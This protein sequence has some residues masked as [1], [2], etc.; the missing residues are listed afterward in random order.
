MSTTKRVAIVGAVLSAVALVLPVEALTRPSTPA[1]RVLAISY[2]AHDGLSRRAYLILPAWYGPKKHPPIPLVISP[3]GRGVGARANIRRWGD[4]PARGGFAVINPEGQGRRLTLFSWGDPGEIRDLARMPSI[5]ERAATWL[6]I[7]RRRVYAFGGSMGGQETLLLLARYPRL[8]AGA[9]S[10]DA[11]TNM[12]ARYRA[13]DLLPFGDGLQRLA[14]RE[15][16]GTPET[17][18]DGYESRSPLDYAWKIAFA[19]VPLQIWWSTRD[20]TVSDQKQ[21]SGLLY[22]DIKRLNPS[23]PASEFVGAWAHTTEMAAHGY[24]PYALSRF[25]LMPPRAAPPSRVHHGPPGAI[26]T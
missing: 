15:I 11:P 16:G 6:Q 20:R 19:G 13:F 23:A 26:F 25:G 24:L 5:A 9:A 3:H 2:L 18:P 22:R 12:A 7:D 10:F 21:E 1:V 14:R 4:L 17:D 8:L